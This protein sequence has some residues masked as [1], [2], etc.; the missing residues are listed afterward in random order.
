MERHDT[1]ILACDSA[2]NRMILRGVLEESFNLLEAA[3][4]QQTIL[5]LEQNIHCIAAILVDLNT[6]EDLNR[7]LLLKED[8]AA[9]M[10]DI[11]IIA[12]ADNDSSEV[13]TQAFRLG[14][15]DV[16]PIQYD[17]YAMLKRI[18]NIVE[19]SLHKRHLETLV[20]EQA[21]TLRRSNDAMV[22]A[23]SSIIEY[24]SAES[25]QHILRIRHFTKILLEEL[26]R[27][28]PEYKL[29]DALISIISSA[30]ALHDIG[31]IAIPDSI[32]TKPGKLTPEEWEVM[33]TH[34]LTGCRI[35]DSLSHIGNQEY[36]RYAHN[37][38]HYHHERWD[39]GGYPE[40]LAGNDIPICAQVV[41][42]ADVYDA[43][44]SKRVYKDAYSFE[45]AVNMILNGECGI[46]SPKLL[47]CFKHVT[48]QYESLARAYADGLSPN[49]ENFDV[50][51]PAPNSE[52]ENDSMERMHAKYQALVHYMNVFLME[53]DL[54]R[55]HFHLIYNPYPEFAQLHDLNTYTEIENFVQ[56]Q[57]VVP[58][59]RERIDHFFH[60][61]IPAFLREGLRRVTYTFRFQSKQVPNGENFEVTLLRLNPMNTARNTLAVL[62]RKADNH[63]S[64]ALALENT[65]F[66]LANS[67]FHCRYDEDF[68]LKQLGPQTPMLAGYTPEE[69]RDL[70]DNKIIQLVLPEDRARMRREFQEQLSRGSRAELEFRVRR[71]DSRIIWVLDKSLMVMAEDGQ[72]YLHSF[73]TDITST[74]RN[75]DALNNKL[76]RYEIILAQTENVLFDWDIQADEINISDTWERIFGI[77]PSSETGRNILLNGSY[78]HPD[79]LPLLHSRIQA[80]QNG[81]DYE[82]LEVRI[83]TA[84]G[85]YL[86]CRIR[87][88]AVRDSSGKLEKIAGIIINIDAE[89]QAE[90]VL[91]DRAERDALTKLLNKQTGRK[92]AEEYFAQFP[93]GANC[94]LLIIDLDNFKQ[95]NDQ[96]GHLFGD[97]VLTKTA[98]EIKKLF[99]TQDIVAR[100]GGD[101]FMVLMR[102]VSDRTLV[103][104]RCTR[105]LAA[106]R[107]VFQDQHNKLPLGCSIG[108]ALAP[109]HGTTY[110]D[111]FQH[112]DQALYQ[113]KKDGKGNFVFYNS[114]DAAF[115]SQNMR[116]TAINN[117]IDS[118]EQPGLADSS[119]VQYAFQRLYASRNV[120]ASIHDILDLMGR[121]LNVSRVYVFEDSPDHK[122]C[123][124]TYEWCN[125]GIR[126]DIQNL[127]HL[128][129]EMYLPGFQDNFDEQGIFH[130]SDISLL[131]R[132]TYNIV[133]R[134]NVKSLLLCAIRDKGVFSG[135]IGFDECTTQRIWTKEKIQLLSYF[136]EML[137]VFLLKKRAQDKTQQRANDLSSILDNQNAWI[138]IIDPETFQL[139]YLNK[140][141]KLLAPD[142]KPG[143]CCYKVLTGREERCTN[144][145]CLHIQQTKT[146]RAVLKN[147][148]FHKEVTAEATLIQWEGTESCLL[149]CRELPEKSK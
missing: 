8:L 90:R 54:D 131:P 120:D 6:P 72:E 83:A 25:G 73:L 32:L 98:R 45:T 3:N 141:T 2:E 35:L 138:Y 130:C 134:Q 102:S 12:I 50:T 127:Q 88:S 52:D 137:S 109:E 84:K 23:L 60:E 140:K 92:Q 126:P 79:D 93:Q 31:K 121:Q 124:N 27:C 36:L 59:E 75:Y 113:A 42:L 49:A 135:F 148:R 125:T 99:R 17:S 7:E 34:S 28:C 78:F 24:R 5:L 22:D 56:E 40:G 122:F 128:D 64:A 104:S 85:R 10:A 37:I 53:L 116:T 51:L 143:M 48:G 82:M 94:A 74:K 103:E 119:I 13:L 18:E 19:L 139:K 123:S 114:K 41:G 11:P 38:C 15:A 111:L 57:L 9:M 132:A 112:A 86:W 39:G 100:I 144:C 110:Y 147:V 145:P 62:W 21:D 63:T 1:L 65:P 142:A 106:F 30:S 105:L 70:F 68:T 108:I 146:D 101:E 107:S 117:H 87:A 129:Y 55:G 71:K 89:K 136:S 26:A 115:L 4:L 16:I 81:S 69:L 14:A 96:Y 46:F 149:T 29:S 61:D 58:Q 91:Q 33:K 44:T 76:N 66:G 80:L 133:A 77:Q 43:L 20:E 97:S 67:T 95:V 118:D 47:E